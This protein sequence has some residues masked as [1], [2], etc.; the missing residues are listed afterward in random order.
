MDKKDWKQKK[1]RELKRPLSDVELRAV[2]WDRLSKDYPKNQR[3]LKR[4]I[5]KIVVAARKQELSK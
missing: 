5:R 4:K 2:V 3:K 1:E